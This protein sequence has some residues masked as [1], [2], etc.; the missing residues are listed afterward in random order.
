M[1]TRILE[2]VGS[3]A[4]I[5]GITVGAAFLIFRDIL[6]KRIFPNLTQMQ[7]YRLLR[8]ISIFA[9]LIALAGIVAW[10]HGVRSG[11]SSSP[12]SA[13]SIEFSQLLLMYMPDHDGALVPWYTCAEQDTPVE[14][15]TSGKREVDDDGRH[16]RVVLTIHGS[17]TH[18]TLRKTYG[19]NKWLI[20]LRGPEV[21][22]DSV[23]IDS[24]S[25]S[26][27][28][29]IQLNDALRGSTLHAA[30]IAENAWGEAKSACCI[31][32]ELREPTKS[33]A[34]LVESWSC[35]SGGCGEEFLL[36]A[37]RDDA[38]EVWSEAK[39]SAEGTQSQEL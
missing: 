36:S 32:Y 17:P 4:G 16:G 25:L 23:N 14:W 5:A 2:I 20:T 22:I 3:I 6:R 26:G 28:L 15:E 12:T 39:R 19:P 30:K 21:G 24:D 34:Y 31:V 38:I 9:F 18:N 10:V 27:D 13:K 33:P 35:G 7:A 29:P 11:N 37:S 8:L 1:E